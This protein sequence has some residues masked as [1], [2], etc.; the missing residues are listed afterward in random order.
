MRSKWSKIFNYTVI[1]AALLLIVWPGPCLKA[2]SVNVH[3]VV[4]D[5][6]TKTP[7]PNVHVIAENTRFST[8]TGPDGRYSLRITGGNILQFSADGFFT[9]KHVLGKSYLQEVNIFLPRRERHLA[10]VVVNSKRRH[11]SNKN[12]P[13][14]E[15]IRKVIAHKKENDIGAYSSASYR[16]YEKLCM[17]LDGFPD[18]ATKNRLMR[19]FRFV[20]E[21]KDSLKVKGK[22]LIPLYIEETVSQN[23]FQREPEKK[24]QVIEGQKK[25]DYGEY[26]DTHGVS[27]ILNR[28]YENINI[29]DNLIVAFTRQFISPIADAAPAFYQYFIEDTLVENGTPL[30]RLSINPRNNNALVFTGTLYITLDGRYA[31]RKLDLHTNK[32]MNLGVVRSFSVIQDFEEDTLTHKY[33]LSYSDVVTDFG[34]T[35]GTAGMYGERLVLF[36]DF[37]SGQQFPDSVFKKDYTREY[38]PLYKPDSFF[39]AYRMNT[40]SDA[41]ARTYYNIDSLHNMKSYILYTDLIRFWSTGYKAAGPVDIGPAYAFVAY[42]PIE[43]WKPRLGGR[44][45]TN[46]STRYF[47]DGYLAYGLRDKQF[48]YYGSVAYSLNN[49]SI[50]KYPMHFVEFSYRHDT[51]VPGAGDDYVDDNPLL[52]F[53]TGSATRYLYNNIFRGEYTYEFANHIGLNLGFKYREQRPAGSLAFVKNNNTVQDTVRSLTTNEVFAVFRWAPHEQFYQNNGYRFAIRNRYPV[54]SLS[55]THGFK[56][57]ASD[58]GYDRVDLEITKRAYWAPFGHTDIRLEAGGILGRLPWPL[59]VIHQGNQSLGY[60]RRGYNLMN[61]FEFV[62]DHYAGISINHAFKGFFFDRIPL[63]KKLKWREVVTGRLLYGG[64]REENRP[65]NGNVFQFP[66]T[67]NRLSTYTLNDGPYFE[68]GAG[69][70]NIFKILRID[71]IKR[72]TYL[73]HPGIRSWGIRWDLRFEL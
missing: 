46:F 65:G 73:D 42:N 51:N 36:S 34:L 14:V 5:S 1:C 69:I 39:T 52:S 28:L 18:W 26:I 59:L 8:R 4:V 9:R 16:Q 21:N 32:D 55:Y 31:V 24:N 25:V 72:F 15:L 45:N 61:S 49:R 20:F 13:A 68:A 30:V 64:L 38:I 3:G 47:L 43:G 60:S 29:Y 10:T 17:Y 44:T 19:Q 58:F 23:Y 22:E 50:Y 37:T 71:I 27:A 57:A 48:K 53:S 7:V 63:L 6:A 40:L 35:K 12:N 54:F 56:T 67:E 11:Y 70:T 2:Q 66:L 62:S 41:E 33:H